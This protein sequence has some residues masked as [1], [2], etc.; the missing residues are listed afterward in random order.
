MMYDEEKRI[1]KE[2]GL[3]ALLFY[4]AMI[5]NQKRWDVKRINILKRDGYTCKRCSRYGKIREASTVHHIY[6]VEFYPEL[7]FINWNLISLC[8]QCH[9]RM[10]DRDTHELTQEGIAL[11]K[12]VEHLKKEF[13]LK[14]ITPPG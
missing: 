8:G 2:Q 4:Y 11:Q 3:T 9:N 13:E 6:P 10:H 7:A 12:K 14:T 5:Y 1:G